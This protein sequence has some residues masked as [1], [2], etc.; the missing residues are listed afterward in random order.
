MLKVGINSTAVQVPVIL[1]L[2][3][4]WCAILYLVYN[5]SIVQ[6]REG[7]RTRLAPINYSNNTCYLYKYS[8]Q[9]MLHARNANFRSGFEPSSTSL[10]VRSTS[11][12]TVPSS[13][14]TVP[15]S[16]DSAGGGLGHAR[17][18]SR[19]SVL[20]NWGLRWDLET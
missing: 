1:L 14:V 20:F 7:S 18:V 16:P 19:R 9:Y 11:R 5:S 15:A 3:C 10:P 2:A 13:C 4:I 8:V 17:A 6:T 12:R